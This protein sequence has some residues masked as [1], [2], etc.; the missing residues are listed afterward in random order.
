[1][2]A[3]LQSSDFI[4]QYDV[5]RICQLLSDDLAGAPIDQAT[6]PTNPTLNAIIAE[7][8]AMFDSAALV[9]NRYQTSD[10]ASAAITYTGTTG[11][12]GA[13]IRRTVGNLTWGLLNARRGLSEQELSELAP[14]Y[15]DALSFLEEMRRGERVLNID[16][17]PAA[18]LP[19]I[20]Q[21]GSNYNCSYA[22]IANKSRL[23]MSFFGGQWPNNGG[24][25]P[26]CGCGWGGS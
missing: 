4:L 9:D 15:N 6:L 18:G 1:M 8:S 19:G 20:A 11:A 7:A 14:L 2:A 5:N 26:G 10:L 23:W 24:G 16:G 17:G 21:L 22:L 3:Y 25:G 13:L 12:V